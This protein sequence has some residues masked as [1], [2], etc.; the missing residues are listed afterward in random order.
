MKWIAKKRLQ[1]VLGLSVVDGQLRVAHV[2]RAKSAIA[3]VRSASAKL[4][5][6]LLHPEAEL[7]GR[8]IKNHL[9]AAGIRERNCV[10]ALPPSWIMTQHAKL[11]ELSAEDQASLLQIEAEKGFPVDPDEL[12]IA[13]SPHRSSESAY[14]TQLAVRRDQLTRLS[15]VLKAAGLKPE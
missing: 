7:V 4:S 2:A 15:T 11:P 3:V 10:I 6:D 5:L 14:V 13:R 1:S 8:E 12:Q 9:E